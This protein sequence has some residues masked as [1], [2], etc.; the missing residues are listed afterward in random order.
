VTDAMLATILYKALKNKPCACPHHW[1]GGK[2]VPAT[3]CEGHK[4]MELYENSRLGTQGI[5]T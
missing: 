5:N 4:A 3:L 2:F 1:V